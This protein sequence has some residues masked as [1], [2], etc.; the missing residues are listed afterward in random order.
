MNILKEKQLTQNK[1]NTIN[2]TIK[3]LIDGV[4]EQLIIDG[5]IVTGESLLNVIDDSIFE[6]SFKDG[7]IILPGDFSSLTWIG[8]KLIK[9]DS[10]ITITKN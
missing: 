2:S 9:L 10:R 5:G 3:S 7:F 8:F 4:I 1:I 6:A